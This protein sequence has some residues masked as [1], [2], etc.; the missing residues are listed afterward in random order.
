MN[1]KNYIRD[2][3]DFPT[4]G[5]LFRD[6]TPLLKDTKAFKST[7]DMFAERYSDSRIDAIVGIESRGFMFAAPLSYRLGVP[8][9][10]IRK[11][12][13]LPFDTHKVSYDLEYGSDAVEVHVDAITD[14]NSV[15][16]VDDL[17]ATGG[18]LAAST[19][20]IEQAGAEVAGLAIVIELDDL[21]GRNAL[22]KYDIHSLIHY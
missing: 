6:I 18:T 3:P 20:L 12:G 8:F 15:L 7:I 5:I 9:V 14:G 11:L 4:P 22:T 1:L 13:K 16:I 19:Q 21:E 2:V 10:P 17:L